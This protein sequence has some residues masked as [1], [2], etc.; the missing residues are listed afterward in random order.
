MKLAVIPA[1]GGS[2]RIPKKNIRPFCG[3]PIIAYSIAAAQRSGLFDH[4]VVSTDCEEIATV[5]R[6]WG[7][8]VPFIRPAALSDDHCGVVAVVEHAV[9]WFRQSGA[10]GT[11]TVATDTA[12][13]NGQE[14]EAVCGIYATAPLLRAEDLRAGF[15]LLQQDGGR[16]M[17]VTTFPFP[18]QRA[19]KMNSDGALAMF[20]PEHAMSRSQDLEPAYHD[21]A[22]FFW[23]GSAALA[24]SATNHRGLVLPRYRVQ[25]I[26]SEEDWRVAEQLYQLARMNAG[27]QGPAEGLS[28][29]Q[30]S[31]A[32]ASLANSTA[33]GG[34]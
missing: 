17:A 8:E 28:A 4:I 14:L 24:G 12:V 5:A 11:E 7:A 25:D 6:E 15:E 33:V 10:T 31:T 19:L 21:A 20:Q 23:W 2:K 18:I 27:E 22:Q 34:R 9:E 32:S 3:R 16:V 29:E 13:K 26:D 30:L 1:R